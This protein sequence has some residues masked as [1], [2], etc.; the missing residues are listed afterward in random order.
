MEFDAYLD[1]E[2]PALSRFAGVLAGNPHDA[3]DVL[4]DAMIVVAARWDRI[5]GME[6]PTAYV[7][8]VIVSTFL[9][10]RR[11]AA[12]RR[13]APVADDDVLDHPVDDPS[14]AVLV[15]AETDRLLASLPPRQR[16]AVVLRYYLDLD[17]AAIAAALGLSRGAVRSS[18]S[19]AL[20]TLRVTPD[21][22]PV[23]P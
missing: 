5:A 16:A 11:K 23:E 7:R 15:R 14:E 19:R 2:L 6:H 17:D 12:R 8:R 22:L 3:H 10:D 18:V 13:T 21:T 20:A 9:S 1:R 4:A